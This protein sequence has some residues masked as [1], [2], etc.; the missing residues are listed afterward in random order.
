LTR[1]QSIQMKCADPSKECTKEV[2]GKRLAQSGVLLG[3]LRLQGI[4]VAK[5]MKLCHPPKRANTRY[6]RSQT[7]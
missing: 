1:R 3:N 6:G 4:K 7:K 5:L 2:A